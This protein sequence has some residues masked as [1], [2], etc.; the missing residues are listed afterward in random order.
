MTVLDVAPSALA[1]TN[2]SEDPYPL[3][4]FLRDEHPVFYDAPHDMFVLTRYED[5]SATLRDHRTFSSI[6]LHILRDENLRISPLREQDQPRHTFLRRI[7]MPMFTPAEMR[8]W[9]PYYRRLA[10]ELLDDAERRDA[11]DVTPQLAVPLPGRVTCDLL[12]VPVHQHER[13]LALTAE[14]LQ[15][16]HTTDGWIEDRGDLRPLEE[17]AADLWAIVREA[18]DARRTVPARDAITLL[19]N[20]QAEHGPDQLSDGEIIDMLLHLLTGGFHT[21]QHLVELLLSFMADRNDLWRRLREDRTLVPSAIEE[22]LRWEAPVQ[23]L[24]RRTT[25]EVVVRDTA[26]PENATLS[27]VYGSANRDERVFDA[28][29]TYLLERGQTRH[30]AFAAGVHYCPGAPV[31]RFEVRALLDEM[32]D[33]YDRIERVGPSTPLARGRV[34]VESFRGFD[35]VPVRLHR[36]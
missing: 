28:P 2:W 25:C 12:G 33:R 11:I 36:G 14:R 15:L 31:S 35:S 20:A 8:R 7:I 5:V 24:R 10:Q 26:I 6:P 21:T 13:F 19:V 3:Y 16:L 23:A 18:V 1:W 22:M 27:L 4:R 30:F 9:D 32:L 29:D 17:I 34:T